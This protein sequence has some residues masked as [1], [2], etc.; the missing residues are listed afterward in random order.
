MNKS[1]FNCLPNFWR[2]TLCTSLLVVTACSSVQTIDRD[3]ASGA[4]QLSAAGDHTAASRSYLD[5][6]VAASGDQR[7]RF[8]IFA[9][10]ELYL[11]N[12]LSGAEQVLE[13]AGASIAET[14]LEVWAETTA[15][16][17]L[18]R[19]EPDA[20]LA[21]LN[22]VTSTNNRDSAARILLLRSNALF[23][24][25]RPK[26]AVTSLVQR[27]ALL[28]RRADIDSNRRLIW[29]GMQTTGQAIGRESPS[30]KDSAIVTGWLEI[31]ELAYM[32]R[33]SLGELNRSLQ[34][35]QATNPLH[36]ASAGLL[37]EVLEN[38]GALSN[39]P[40]RV[41]LLL[42]LSGRQKVLGESLRDGYMAAH[43]NLGIETERPEIRVYDTARNGAVAAYQ[44]A[45]LNGADFVVGPLLKNEISELAEIST[46]VTV[47]ALNYASEDLQTP[48]NFYQFALSPED[49]AR[50]AAD[51]AADEG[52]FNAVALVP[53]TNWGDRVLAAFSEQLD[54]R[55]GKLLAAKSYQP[56]AP[57]F[58]QDIREVL[59]LNESY[60]RRNR[61]AANIGKS[62]EF[63]PRRRQDVDLV[64]IGAGA[65]AAKLLKPQLRF[66]YAGELPTYATSAIYQPGSTNNAD[67]NGLIFP[68]I[69]WLLEP[70][71]TVQE[72]Q[73][74]LQR[75]WGKG[76]QQ[77][78]RFYAMGYDAYHLTAALNHR[79]S[80]TSLSMQGA[81][82]LLYLDRNGQ[83]HRELRWARMERGKPRALPQRPGGLTQDAEITLSQQQ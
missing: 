20:A 31:G 69:P 9:A 58:S 24:L 79:S 18:A 54:R 30:A 13:Q 8:L 29:S 42:P 47:L 3:T 35:W 68:D 77:R 45:M 2:A 21:A 33:G 70:N 56:D 28:D 7:Q 76:A 12:D 43:F 80:R 51:R 36:P 53:D 59:L 62:V 37:N 16:I 64:F 46:D 32:N 74:T 60:A 23:Q 1:I 4:Q 61:L 5:L 38:L 72:N 26:A 10:A 34:S 22:Q 57:D 17:K 27:E 40:E 66:H 67:L 82:G 75:F 11:A 19:S 25:E 49:E 44:Q 15:Q 14:N 73:L 6:A 71:Q 78:A 55:G 52:L 83:I 50:A 39:Y 65:A 41:A 81:T 63:E 48:P